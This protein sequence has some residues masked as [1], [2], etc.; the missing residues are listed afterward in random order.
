MVRRNCL[1]GAKV[2]GNPT[3][4]STEVFT[5]YHSPKCMS[6]L[7]GCCAL[8]VEVRPTLSAGR[9]R[10]E[11]LPRTQNGAAHA[12]SPEMVEDELAVH[13]YH[14]RSCCIIFMSMYNDIDWIQKNN[15]ADK[16]SCVM[17]I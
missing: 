13:P 11:V 2:L 17:F 7:T 12:G 6:S 14:S 1:Y 5:N 4:C 16:H 3:P 10:G 9:V 15:E 8:V